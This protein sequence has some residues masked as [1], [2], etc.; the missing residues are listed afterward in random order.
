[1]DAHEFAQWKAY[2]QLEPFGA[3]RDNLHAG[4]IAASLSGGNPADF[5]VGGAGEV[6]NEEKMMN[7][8]KRIARGNSKPN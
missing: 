4:I 2:Y 5:L 6:V 7:T 3:D 8:A 1:M